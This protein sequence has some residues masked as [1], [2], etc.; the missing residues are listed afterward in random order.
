[1]FN[2]FA[3][4][5]LL[6]SFRSSDISFGSFFLWKNRALEYCLNSWTPELLQLAKDEL[7]INYQLQICCLQ[8]L[9]AERHGI[10][11]PA[12]EEGPY[13]LGCLA[14]LMTAK[15]RLAP[16]EGEE[17]VAR[18]LYLFQY[19]QA[20]S[21]VLIIIRFARGVVEQGKHSQSVWL[22]GTV[23]ALQERAGT[24][25]PALPDGACRHG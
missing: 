25:G 9:V 16:V 1:M 7:I 21:D 23:L 20:R 4:T 10:V 8:E 12:V 6:W 3:F 22:D 13:Q 5:Q 14:A 15:Q 11:G 19:L 18:A 2:Y 24:D 17:D